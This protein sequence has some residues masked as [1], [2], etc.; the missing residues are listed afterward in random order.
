LTYHT[1]DLQEVCKR[2]LDRAAL[3][4]AGI[5]DAKSKE[6]EAAP[7]KYIQDRHRRLMQ[8]SLKYL[9]SNQQGKYRLQSFSSISGY[10][11]PER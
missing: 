2:L 11:N 8:L 7:L 3:L 9:F 6:W 5:N 10:E 1:T 4:T